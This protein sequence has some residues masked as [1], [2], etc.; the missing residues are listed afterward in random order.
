M[1]RARSAAGPTSRIAVVL[2]P[3]ERRAA[4]RTLHWIHGIPQHV[5]R[6]RLVVRDR[7]PQ[8]LAVDGGAVEGVL[9]A[10]Q[11]LLEQ[12][13]LGRVGLGGPEPGREVLLGVEP[14]G[15]LRAGAGRRL[16][17]HRQSDLGEEG[18][19][20]VGPGHQL[21]PGTRHAGGSEHRLHPRLV[22]DV[23]GG[24]L[25]HAVDP[26]LAADLGERHLQLFQGADQ[27]LDSTELTAQATD[28]VGDLLRV[29]RVGHPPVTGQRFAQRRRHVL[30]RL[31]GDQAEADVRQSGGS[32]RRTSSSPPGDTVR[33]TR[34]PP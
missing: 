24:L 11:V 3:A 22:P 25:V 28:G 27:P 26:E 13:D 18:G 31:G 10:G 33:R 16:G 4:A 9:A 34:R 17:N 8:G 15:G 1:P 7:R 23:V 21:V 32:Q 19:G 2:G 6:G 20:L 12:P 14:V 5:Q 30:E 29:K